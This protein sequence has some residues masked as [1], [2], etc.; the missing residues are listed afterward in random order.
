M[1]RGFETGS[2]NERIDELQKQLDDVLD[3]QISSVGGNEDISIDSS[4]G[5]RNAASGDSGGVRSNEPI[6]H[7]ITDIDEGGTPTGDFD[8]INIISSM[9]IIDH[10]STPITLRF[11]QG[12]VKDGARI[13]ITPKIGKTIEVESGGN[14]L[15]TSTITI[16]DGDYYELVKYS[17]AETG[18]TGGAFKIFLTGTGAGALSEPIELGFNEVVTQTPPT[19]TIIAGDVFN[20]SHVD[21]DQ[22]I[23]LQLDISATV[24]KYKS[25]FVIFDTTG[26]GFTVTWPAS[27]VNPPVI[28]DTVAQRISV[29]LYSIDNGVLWTHATSVGSSSGGAEFFGPWTANHDAGV[30]SLVNLAAAAYVDTLGFPRGTIAG[31]N[32]AAALRLSLATGGKLIISDVLI[33]IVSFDDATGITIEGSHV[34]NM[35]NNIINTISELQFSNANLHTPSNELSIAFDSGLGALRYSVPL[36]TN[37]HQF[38]ADTDLLATFSRVG[39]NEGLLSIQAVTATFLQAT[40]TLFLS[41]FDNTTPT[42]GDVWRNLTGFFQFQENG[43]TVGLGGAGNEISQGDSFVRVTDVG[44]GVVNFEVDSTP[45]GSITTAF[46]WAL[47]IGIILASGDLTL[48]S[49]DIILGNGFEIRNTSANTTTFA[50]PAVE[51]LSITES[52]AVRILIAEDLLFSCASNDDILFQEIGVTVGRYDGGL[53][54]WIFNE[55]VDFNGIVGDIIG[56]TSNIL[57]SLAI[58]WAALD[59]NRVNLVTGGVAAGILLVDA[60]GIEINAVTT[61]DFIELKTQGTVR[62]NF[63]AETDGG[64]TFFEPFEIND[65]MRID[66]GNMIH[67]ND[68]IQCGFA[69]TNEVTSPGTEG[70]M[71]MPRT[72]D[73]TPTAADFDADFGDAIGC[74]GLATLGG[75]PATPIYV[76]KV[77][78]SPSTWRGLILN[79]AGN[80]GATE[81][82]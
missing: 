27:V 10:T 22:D 47:E 74:H 46:G 24:S 31:D 2:D 60:D 63:K 68:S 23:E 3:S 50:I 38:F 73:T 58:P 7:Q 80:I 78:T 13:K 69:V 51:F 64:I 56:T 15:T 5:A 53:N 59:A 82:T 41:T 71:Q 8:K 34:I 52:G 16:T 54:N 20:P 48:S 9:A 1:A 18:V 39:V 25:L 75:L 57:G 37:V 45:L 12:T 40:E 17:E 11:I 4:R 55:P 62:A 49:G 26:G 44:V 42:N 65:E 67:A 76:I 66:G 32:G 79:S 29:I 43:V 72:S 28:P 35:G 77:G 6:I 14:I 30:K 33:D 36:T 70:T 19:L 61:G 21:L 81:F